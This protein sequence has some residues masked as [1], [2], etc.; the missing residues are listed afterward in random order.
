VLPA[1]TRVAWQIR[2]Q[3]IRTESPSATRK[4]FIYNLSRSSYEKNWG[5]QYERPGIRSR[6]LVLVFRIVPPIGP[7]RALS[8]KRLTPETE[9][10]YMASFNSTVD[11]YRELLIRKDGGSL[12]LP[13]ENLDVGAF[14]T[15]GEYRLTDAAYAR[16]LHKLQA[17]Y[18][19]IP[20]DLRGDMLA[21]YRDLDAPIATKS[22]SDEWARVLRELDRL[23]SVDVDLRR[24]SVAALP[25]LPSR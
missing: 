4:K 16:L 12:Q 15:A 11:R 22:D 10:M 21:F 20:A 7:F 8:F 6:F 5:S 14:A 13:N 17:H 25:A 19:E 1:V 3:T 9:R 23:R 24:P 2:K 18:T